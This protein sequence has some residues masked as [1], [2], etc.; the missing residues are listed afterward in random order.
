MEKLECLYMGMEGVEVTLESNVA[1]PR[2]VKHSIAVC[3]CVCVCISCSAV[4][5]SV[6]HGL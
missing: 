6:T 1:Y 4:S 2:K 3:V 5:D